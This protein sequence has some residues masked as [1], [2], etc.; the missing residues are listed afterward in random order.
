[1]FKRIYIKKW[2]KK[3][4]FGILIYLNVYFVGINMKSMESALLII[5]LCLMCVYVPLLFEKEN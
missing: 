3:I 4:L 5:P 2:L 1:M